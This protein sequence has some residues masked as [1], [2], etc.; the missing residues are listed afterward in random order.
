MQYQSFTIKYNGLSNVLKSDIKVSLPADNLTPDIQLH[1]FKAIWDTGATHSVITQRVASLLK[2]T[3]T[4]FREVNTAGGKVLK[5]VYLVNF[6][7]PNMVAFNFV[8]VTEMDAI[9]G[10]FDVLIGM[11]I[12]ASGDFAVTNFQG[13]TTFTYRYPPLSEIDFVKDVKTS[14]KQQPIKSTHKVGRNDPCPCNS[15]MKYKNC[16]G[17]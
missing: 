4:T 12:I 15:G 5:K 9:S 14:S 11:D 1:E 3:Q 10:D 7:L 16:H 17:K 6:Y 8:E 13:K 2:L